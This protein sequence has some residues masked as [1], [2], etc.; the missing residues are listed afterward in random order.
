MTPRMSLPR[1][2]WCLQAPLSSG[3]VFQQPYRLADRV[4]TPDA[5]CPACLLLS[6]LSC[7]VY[8][9]SITCL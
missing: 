6:A 5:Y 3:Y 7:W 2:H 4:L 1:L 8:I 9:T